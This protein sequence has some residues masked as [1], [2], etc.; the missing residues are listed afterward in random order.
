M[1]EKRAG[2]PLT[3]PVSK[4]L[5]NL[6]GAASRTS[7]LTTVRNPCAD[8]GRVQVI[9]DSHAGQGEHK[10]DAFLAHGSFDKSFMLRVHALLTE[11]G[12]RPFLDRLDWY[13]T[14]CGAVEDVFPIID[15]SRMVVVRVS[16]FLIA[17][18]FAMSEVR[19]A[20]EA[21][22]VVPVF[23]APYMSLDKVLEWRNDS[24]TG[25][26]DFMDVVTDLVQEEQAR[27]W[28]G[29][30][31]SLCDDE[32]KSAKDLARL[33]TNAPP[34]VVEWR[35]DRKERIQLVF[36][37]ATSWGCVTGK[38][39]ELCWMPERVANRVS[40]VLRDQVGNVRRAVSA[41]FAPGRKTENYVVPKTQFDDLIERVLNGGTSALTAVR[42]LAGVGK[43][44][45]AR[46]AATNSRVV[47]SF[48]RVLW[49]S[50]G[51]RKDVNSLLAIS[52]DLIKSEL[53]FDA[54]WVNDG[55]ELKRAMSAAL[56]QAHGRVLFIFDDV[57]TREQYDLLSGGIKKPHSV[58]VT[59]RESICLPYGTVPITLEL[60]DEEAAMSVFQKN[61][62]EGWRDG[63]EPGADDKRVQ[64]LVAGRRGHALGLKILGCAINCE[65]DLEEMMNK[66]LVANVTEEERKNDETGA[67][68]YGDVFLV[69]E[70]VFTRL[71]DVER[72]AYAVCGLFPTDTD[73]K[74]DWV[75]NLLILGGMG[76]EGKKLPKKV[77]GLAK[78]ALLREKRGGVLELHDLA[79]EYLRTRVLANK[80]KAVDV[81]AVALPTAQVLMGRKVELPD[82]VKE[83]TVELVG[84]ALRLEEDE[85]LLAGQTAGQYPGI[86]LFLLDLDLKMDGPGRVV[87][88]ALKL[89]SLEMRK[90]ELCAGVAE[91]I[92]DGFV[93]AVKTLQ[94]SKVHKA[95][96][97][98]LR[99]RRVLDMTDEAE[100]LTDGGLCKV[101][102]NYRHA[103]RVI[104]KGSTLVTDEGVLAVLATCAK[105]KYLDVSRCS[106]GSK[107]QTELVQRSGLTFIDQGR[108]TLGITKTNIITSELIER[109]MKSYPELRELSLTQCGVELELVVPMLN[110]YPSLTSL[111]L[112][113]SDI[114]SNDVL[115]F[116]KQC[117]SLTS[118]NL[119]GCSGITS[120]AVLTFT[121]QCT[122]LTSLNLSDCNRI[123]DQ[124]VMTLAEHCTS[125]TSLNLNYCFRITDPAVLA[126]A[127]ACSSLTSINLANCTEI[128][129]EAVVAL[130]THC[131]SLTALDL[132][133]CREIT[134]G[135]LVALAECS[136]SLTKLYLRGCPKITE[137]DVDALIDQYEKRCPNGHSPLRVYF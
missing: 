41:R 1:S 114:T 23:M 133:N 52:R 34:K 96:D 71:D 111:N 64:K 129:D 59:T 127:T 88:L 25:V 118:L 22:C 106:I 53:L 17:S 101:L 28:L 120:N 131:I 98:A 3:G 80:T 122:S 51:E 109:V 42:G 68:V 102:E 126:L 20:L 82:E 99:S 86:F 110:H 128:T 125:L 78:R 61:L 37:L 2:D 35:A 39:N 65:N 69:M 74:V 67:L 31:V 47:E 136:A 134:N 132:A 60:L 137:R 72:A 12:F 30:L 48:S 27:A 26:L 58:L 97:V 62:A 91:C 79:V 40:E 43:S 94:P 113:G 66:N 87:L 46:A 4:S 55:E 24:E 117:A 124:A 76:G 70:A 8:I 75:V 135:A 38:S 73:I 6:E 45:L 56:E 63:A 32:V 85:S 90:A 9:H 54:S 11:R 115:T 103:Q 92:L 13:G 123:K 50:V 119:A 93:V 100:G 33:R 108:T 14:R 130:G 84:K 5:K 121:K 104:L 18:E 44:E 21:E 36:Q 16:E 95:E 77:Q 116:T 107:A 81:L 112:A 89:L 83:D 49:I 105:L 19:C 57:W 15:S 29:E 10:Y 7:S